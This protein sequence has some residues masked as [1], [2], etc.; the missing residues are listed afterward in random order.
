[1]PLT[2]KGRKILASMREQYGEEEGERVFY[3]SKNAGTIS[4]VDKC[5]SR[6]RTTTTGGYY[7]ETYNNRKRNDAQVPAIFRTFPQRDLLYYDPIT[8]ATRPRSGSNTTERDPMGR[9]VS[10]FKANPGSGKRVT[11]RDPMG[12]LLNEYEEEDSMSALFRIVGD[13]IPL[14]TTLQL[15]DKVEFDDAAKVTFTKDGYMTA[16]PRVAKVGIQLYHGEECGIA[17]MDVVRV[18]RPESTVFSTDALKTFAHKPVTL[19]HPPVAVTAD[20]WKEYSVGSIGDEVL[21]E[22]DAIRVPMTLMDKAAIAAFKAGTNQ[23]SVGYTCD[24]EWSP[25]VTPKGEHYDAVQRNIR[26]NHLAVVAVARGGPTLKI[27]DHNHPKEN[28]MNLKTVMVDGI[29]CQMTDTAAAL[30]QRTISALQD[31]FEEEKKNGKKKDED[32]KDAAVKITEMATQLGTK[33]AEIVTLK[34]QLADAKLTPQQLDALVKD[35]H[36]A[37]EKARRVLGDKLMVDGKTIEDMRKQVVDAKLGA[38]AQ[39]WSDEQIRASFDTLTATAP[40]AGGVADAVRVFAGRPGNGY[41]PM[42]QFDGSNPQH[43]RDAAY[44][45]SVF[46]M[47]HAWMTPEQRKAAAAAQGFQA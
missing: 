2:E 39:G 35:R 29:E 41:A 15:A 3:A 20:N 37:V 25:G 26:A 44:A 9:L 27:G 19:D 30:V 24:L 13:A 40:T 28:A 7:G 16:T 14:P 18:Y 42:P 36:A 5:N 43:I 32:C 31:A 6:K 21:R 46:D 4:G 1:M 38:A 8:G 47:T 12:R 34:K 33:D 22:G 17:D 23:L 45:Q 11:R 10:E